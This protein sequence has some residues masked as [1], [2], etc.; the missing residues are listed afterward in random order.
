MSNNRNKATWNHMDFK[1]ICYL[2]NLK[3]M[4]IQLDMTQQ[5]KQGTYKANRMANQEGASQRHMKKPIKPKD[6]ILNLSKYIFGL[7]V[8]Q[9]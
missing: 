8:H 6:I 4:S 5:G 1:Q 7:M 2:S 3:A 9:Q